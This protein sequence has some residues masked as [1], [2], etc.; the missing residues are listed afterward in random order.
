MIRRISD[1]LDSII[2]IAKQALSL[3]E[4]LFEAKSCFVVRKRLGHALDSQTA[5]KENKSSKH[6]A[7]QYL[8]K[9]EPQGRGLSSTPPL[10]IFWWPEALNCA[11]KS[12]VKIHD[13]VG[14]ESRRYEDMTGSLGSSQGPLS[15]RGVPS[16]RRP[17][18]PSTAHTNE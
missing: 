9:R 18:K 14:Q 2:N 12:V 8:T 10:P 17:R 5:S 7:G 1:A 11:I 16:R 15:T 6:K 4:G 13:Q 3:G